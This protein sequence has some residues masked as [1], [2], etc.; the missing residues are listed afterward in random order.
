MLSGKT[1]FISALDWGLGHATRCVSLIRD[2]EKNNNIIIGITPLT[3]SIF[4]NEF[5]RLEK[6]NVPA[7]N[8]KYSPI[9]PL[10]LKLFLDWPRIHS[11][12]KN[13][14]FFLDDYV[15]K[16]KIDVVISDNRFGFHSKNVH[17]IFITHQLFLKTPFANTLAQDKNKKYILN[18]D[19]VW[20]PDFEEENKSL[21]GQ[22]SHGDQFHKN[23][24]Y[25][26]PQSRLKKIS[27]E[28][29]FDYLFLLSG[30]EPQRSILKNNLVALAGKYPLL[31]FALSEQ[32]SK[33]QDI[34]PEKGN[35]KTFISPTSVQLSELI[36]SS[37]KIICRSGYSSLMDLYALEKKEI[38]LVPTPGQTEQEYL[39]EYWSKKFNA[40]KLNQNKINSFNF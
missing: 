22:L 1:I 28:K 30:P 25:I 11:V 15:S 39:A 27:S 9:L 32:G 37:N 5:P 38:I 21:S 18:F 24:R 12:I 10:W 29:K 14:T 8:I 6:V 26:G 3:K 2:L 17:S 4:D 35:F 34:N 13:E 40:I 16:N 31:T 20:V 33:T 7:Y 19:E 36:C 23:V